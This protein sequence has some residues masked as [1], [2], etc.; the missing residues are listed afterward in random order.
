MQHVMRKI[1]FDTS[2]TISRRHRCVTHLCFCFFMASLS[3]RLKFFFI[4]KV[5]CFSLIFSSFLLLPLCS[6]AQ[7][8]STTTEQQMEAVTENNEDNET[9]DDSFLQSLQ[10]FLK[11][12][13]NLN[14]AD[15]ATL[16]ELIVLTPL[17]IQ[18]IISYRTLFGKFINIYEL[19]AVPALDITTIE[20]IRPFITVNDA[21][22]FFGSFKDRLSGGTHSVVAR[23]TRVLETS[24]GY[25]LD[26]TTANNYYPGSPQRYFFRYKYQYKNLLQFGVVADKDAGEEFFKGTQKNGFDFYS[27]HLFVRNIGIIKSLALGDFTVNMGQGL[28]QWQSLAFKKSVDVL[29][30]KRQLPVLRPY[31][32]AGEINF[33]RGIGITLAKKSFEFTGF[34]SY[35]SVDANFVTDTLNNEDFISSLQTS[36]LHRTKSETDDKGTQKQLA[37]GG[38]IAYNKNRLHLGGNVIQYQ[39]KF[40]ITKANDPYNLYALSGK[41]IGNQSIDYSYTFRNLH[42]FGEAAMDNKKNKAFVNGLLL[43]VAANADMSFVYRNISPG[44]QSLYTNAFTESTFPSNEKGLYTGIS[45]KPHSFWRVDAYADFYKFPWLK[46]LVDAPTVGVDYLAQLTYK[47]NKQLEVYAR[48]RTETKPKNYNPDGSVTAP[49]VPKQRQNFR[50]QISYK[51]NPEFTFRNRLELVWYD[52]SGSNPQNGFLTYADV[53]YKPMLKKYSGNVRLMYFE[54]GGYDSRMYAYE[55]DVL[56]SFSIPVFYDKGYRWYINLNYDFSK[57]LSFWFRL[58]QTIYKDKTTVGSGLDEINGNRKTEVKLQ[59]QYYF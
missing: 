57:K 13:V 30:V 11:S 1:S 12:P 54:T 51:I 18:N 28:T 49:V 21:P 56:Y 16:K 40:P 2:N 33:H 25:L 58:A 26:S 6:V 43:S 27:A 48:Y 31:N 34:V 53:I 41:N 14:T 32:S 19:Q 50:C 15:A 7:V 23:V 37:Y 17:Q 39:F 44:Y 8:P 45:V 38:N 5:V 20:K 35:K 29:N 47:P 3:L 55:N 22:D 59:L 36:G 24:K 10:Q 9:Q 46:Y 42:F 52:R 4:N